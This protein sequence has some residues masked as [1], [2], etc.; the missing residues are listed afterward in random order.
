MDG[1]AMLNTPASPPAFI[2]HSTWPAGVGCLNNDISMMTVASSSCWVMLASLCIARVVIIRAAGAGTSIMQRFMSDK[3]AMLLC[4]ATSAP[5]AC[6]LA[7]Q[8]LQPLL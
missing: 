1:L 8:S 6:D 7:F 3:T 4:N 5:L 2:S